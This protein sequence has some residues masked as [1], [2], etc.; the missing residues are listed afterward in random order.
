MKR[1]LT[2]S[3]G[4][5][6]PHFAFGWQ[7]QALAFEGRANAAHEQFHLGVQS[8]LQGKFTEIASRLKMEDAE[9]HALIGQCTAA[10]NEASAALN[11]SRTSDNLELAS[12]A[13][14]LC[15]KATE[16][17]N[18]TGELTKRFPDATFSNRVSVP[19]TAA[20]IAIRRGD[21]IRALALM[22]AVV[23]DERTTAADFW[24][25]YL[26]GQAHLQLH[27][28][29][30]AAAEFK[31]IANDRGREPLSLLFPLAH[32]GLARAA[33][34]TNDVDSARRSYEAFFA[35]WR[36]ADSVIEPVREAHVE[37]FRL[38]G[39]RRPVSHTSPK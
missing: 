33:A 26:R 32:L 14:A 35:L 30:K 29:Q 10:R 15:D 4:V 22:D 34:L 8:A 37:Y 5:G 1:E 39:S 3:V 7:A 27:N 9:N 19:I 18:L 13:F 2:S 38:T 25:A 6:E 17:L 36:D 31:A 23:P 12:R 11:L 16:A 24:P 20:I 21:G 28:G